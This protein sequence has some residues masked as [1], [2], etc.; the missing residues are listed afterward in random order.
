MPVTI[1]RHADGS[2]QVSTPTQIH[3]KHM[4]LKHAVAQKLILERASR[5]EAVSK[6]RR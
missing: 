5:D 2:Y 4:T 3:G 6:R 1:R